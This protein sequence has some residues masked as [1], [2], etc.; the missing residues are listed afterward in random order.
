MLSI[1][2]ISGIILLY[3]TNE[4]AVLN[5]TEKLLSIPQRESAGG[6]TAN[7]YN[8]QQIWAFNKMLDML[9]SG[10]DFLLF[11][12]LH[13][14]I[15]ILDSVLNPNFIDFYQIKTNNKP[16]RYIT[17]SFITKNSDKFPIDMSIAQKLIDNFTKF[18]NS[19]RSIH[20]VS[21]KH[22]DLGEL[23]NK[24]KSTE[25]AVICL[26]EISSDYLDQLKKG[27]C[28]SCYLNNNCEDDCINLI[29]FDVSFLDLVNYEDTVLG[30]F[31]NTLNNMGIESSLSKTKAVFNTILGEIK[32]INN[33]E[34]K[35]YDVEEL[36][37][38][39]SISKISFNNWISQFKLEMPDNTWTEIKDY[40]LHDGISSIEVNK[41]SKQWKTYNIDSMDV[42][43]L[44]LN[45][46][47]EHIRKIKESTSC[48]NSK[49][50]L[51]NIYEKVKEIK[52]VK[53]YPKEYIYAMIV[54]EIFS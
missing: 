4:V 40:L 3:I 41:I 28:Q 52:E 45:C 42:D 30:K 39:K 32:R 25:R 19:T 50:W 47:L 31:I 14:D 38:R 34:S 49:E 10:E 20:L 7:R 35:A 22:F 21:N 23:K 2:V 8:Y 51:D 17:N 12:E 13:D 33:W 37:K 11:M 54:K 43:N 36:L 18:K 6:R 29:Y 46:I 1:F 9:V 16:S 26:N 27:M 44:A 53:I 24:D 48:E 5:L 15:L